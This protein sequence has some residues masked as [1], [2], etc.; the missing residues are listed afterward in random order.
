MTAGQRES[1]ERGE[2][3]PPLLI[4]AQTLSEH[5]HANHPLLYTFVILLLFLFIFLN[6]LLFPVN[7]FYATSGPLPFQSPTRCGRRMAPG[8]LSNVST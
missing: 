8:F 3:H 6:S 1:L 4:V 5:L 2:T 7:C